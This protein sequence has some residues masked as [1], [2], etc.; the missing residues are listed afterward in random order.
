MTCHLSFCFQG[1]VVYKWV[2]NEIDIHATFR[3]ITTGDQ[4]MGSSHILGPCLP[5]IRYK[6]AFDYFHMC[7]YFILASGKG[8]HRHRCRWW[9]YNV[10]RQCNTNKVCWLLFR[11]FFCVSYNVWQLCQISSGFHWSKIINIG[12]FLTE[13]FNICVIWYRWCFFGPQYV[14]MYVLFSQVA[15]PGQ[16]YTSCCIV[17]LCRATIMQMQSST[18][19]QADTGSVALP[20]VLRAGETGPASFSV[21]SVQPAKFS[22]TSHQAHTGHM[23]VS[24]VSTVLSVHAELVLFVCRSR[25]SGGNMTSCSMWELWSEFLRGLSCVYRDSHCTACTLHVLSAVPRWNQLS[26]L[27]RTVTLVWCTYCFQVV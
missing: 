11:I 15:F 24:T 13:L 8:L 14:C 19:G 2:R 4:A 18:L 10:W 23:P 21:G 3:H 16:C 17:C 5:C 6:Y 27:C 1:F 12:L 25:W 22:T 26:T 20:A 9:V 7:K